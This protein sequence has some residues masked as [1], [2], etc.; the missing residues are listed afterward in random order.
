M[1]MEYMKEALQEAYEGIQNGHG[2]P[3]GSVIV[4]NGKIMGRGHN[5]VLKNND[6]TAHGEV[7]AIRNACEG[8][9]TYDL[10]GCEI[11]TT[12]EPCPMCLGAILWSGIEKV[13]YGCNCKDSEEIGFRDTAFYEVLEKGKEALCEELGR[14]ECKKLFADYAAIDNH[15]IY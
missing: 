8:M 7:M 13:Y 11:Y 14:N 9:G 5:C 6:P 10:K 3:F 2:G 1:G 12:A 4:K 15:I